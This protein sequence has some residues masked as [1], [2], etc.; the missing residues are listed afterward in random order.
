MS[1]ENRVYPTVVRNMTAAGF[2]RSSEQFQH[3]N[4]AE[5]VQPGMSSHKAKP[6]PEIKAGGRRRHAPACCL[7]SGRLFTKLGA[8]VLVAESPGGY[9]PPGPCGS[10]H[11]CGYFEAAKAHGFALNEDCSSRE[12]KTPGGMVSKAFE[13][14]APILDAD[15]IVDVCKLKTHCMMGLSA[16]VKNMFGVVPGLMKPTTLPFSRKGAVCRILL[17]C[18]AASGP[19]YVLS[20]PSSL[21]RNG[22]SG[23][24]PRFVGA[25]LSARNPFLP[26]QPVRRAGLG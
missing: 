19:I 12:L 10:Y 1:L 6:C 24:T 8:E 9:T 21:W 18:A 16:A 17:T 5:L 14:I 26:G 2:M 4:A 3:L 25:L 15:L 7:R 23:G 11:A 22:P 20:T 13:V